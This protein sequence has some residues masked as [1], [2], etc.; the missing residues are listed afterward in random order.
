MAARPERMGISMFR[1]IASAV[2]AAVMTAATA[3]F[4]VSC[5]ST[6][7]DL[8]IGVILLGDENEGY[9]YAHI[10]GIRTAA[11]KLGL[12][13]DQIIW[14]YSVK[15]DESCADAA[16]DLVDR[17][18]KYIFSNSF[19]HQTYMIDVA[20]DHPDVIFLSAT[21]DQA[22]KCGLD[23]VRNYFTNIFEARYVSGVVAGMKLAEMVEAE[24][25]AEN[26]YDADG[27]IKIGYVGAY[28]YSEVVSGY[29][30]FYL[31][32]KS[33]VENVVMDVQYTNEWFDIPGETEA[34]NSLLARGCVIIGQHSDSTGPASAVEAARANGTN[35]Y[36]VGYNVDM[37]AVAPTAALT[38]AT[39]VWAVYYEYAFK[40][41]VNGDDIAV[42]W[43]RGYSDGAVD[44]T[45]LGAS[46]A[47][48]TAEKVEEVVA[49]IKDGSLHVFD[50]SKF[51]VNGETLTSYTESAGMEGVELISDG[52]F[53]ESEARCA[54]MFDIRIDG[55]TELN[56]N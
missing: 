51:T 37:L 23:N 43:A 19:G 16:I 17:G 42:D 31:G 36:S 9:T 56:N 34:A 35:A 22:A 28:P 47:E 20:K 38:S 4:A 53:H 2:L 5:G 1:K 24:E 13:E 32:I 44:I 14:K 6:N 40:A 3:L 26:N 29:T 45:P 52:Y 10:E 46:C 33:I 21:G 25:L 18:C 15:E 7:D 11:E 48:G 54:P 30:A 55:I 50:T 41:A 27:N 12:K 39:N 8:K 49:A